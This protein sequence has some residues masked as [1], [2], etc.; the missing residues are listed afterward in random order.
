MNVLTYLKQELGANG[1]FMA[2]Y[3]SLS[4]DDKADLKAW[5]V[6]EMGILGIE[7]NN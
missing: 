6:I 1:D 2:S 4:A 3:K 5:A 7:V